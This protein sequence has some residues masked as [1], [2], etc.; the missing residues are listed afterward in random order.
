MRVE[1]ECDFGLESNPSQ[2]KYAANSNVGRGQILYG[3]ER[4]LAVAWF[5]TNARAARDVSVSNVQ[6]NDRF[7]RWRDYQL[8]FP[9]IRRPAPACR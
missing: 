8:L 9:P 4:L 7:G 2:R 6:R 1:F 3:G 5:A